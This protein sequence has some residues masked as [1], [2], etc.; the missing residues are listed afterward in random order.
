M[1]APEAYIQMT[2]GLITEHGEITNES[3]EEFLRKFM[4]EFARFI[5]QVLSVLPARV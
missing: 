2:P 1:N 5:T 3:T 4:H